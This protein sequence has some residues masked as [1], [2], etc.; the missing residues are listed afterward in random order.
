MYENLIES[1]PS[2]RT[3]WKSLNS[4]NTQKPLLEG[5]NLKEE[6][7]LEVLANHFEATFKNKDDT[8]Q[9]NFFKYYKTLKFNNEITLNEFEMN[10]NKLKPKES[11]GFDKI[12][13]LKL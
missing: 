10:L 6:E 1:K 4:N 2:E 5:L 9:T 12:I 3:F 8:R 11:S 13:K 7:K